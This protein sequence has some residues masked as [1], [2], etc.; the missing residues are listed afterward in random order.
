MALARVVGAKQTMRYVCLASA[1]SHT[2][3]S[4]LKGKC[5]PCVP[6]SCLTIYRYVEML[7]NQQ[8]QLVVGLQ[9]LYKRTQNGQG[10]TGPPLK[11]TSHG[12]PLTH[13]ILE[14]LGALKQEGQVSGDV[15]EE[16]LGALQHRLIAS[17]A[18]M[19]Q[20]EPSHDGSS[21][22][23]PSPSYEPQQRPQYSQPFPVSRFPPTPPNQ[24]PYP[25]N[26][27]PVSHHKAQTYPHVA[28]HSNLAWA[29]P[30]SEFDDGMDFINQFDSPMMEAP[31]ELASFHPQMYNE[32][33]I[34]SP[35]LTMKDWSG[36]E[37]MQRYVNPAM[38]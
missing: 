22:S 26:A 17:G 36:Q 31:V 7:E 34:I 14:Q 8:A 16:D 9:E 35:F 13:D 24:S 15:F 38:I 28:T 23:A 18:S 6:T 20:R 33:S 2:T 12:M 30:V 3:R 19:M 37:E 21:D 1:K 5:E 27:R 25:Q 11:E 10:W 32:P 4:I 29:T